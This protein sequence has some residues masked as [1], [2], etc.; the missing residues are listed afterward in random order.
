[1]IFQTFY[2][3]VLFQKMN[4]AKPTVARLEWSCFFCSG[5][6]RHIEFS[7]IQ[8]PDSC[9]GCRGKNI[10]NLKL[11]MLRANAL[12][13]GFSA[14]LKSRGRKTGLNAQHDLVDQK[15]V[16]AHPH[17]H[18]VD[19]GCCHVHPCHGLVLGVI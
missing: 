3:A 2:I 15:S 13:C 6:P 7:K 19:T 12:P 16:F 9:F 11:S 10:L 4:R 5:A 18:R 14:N 1:M 17:I 8:N